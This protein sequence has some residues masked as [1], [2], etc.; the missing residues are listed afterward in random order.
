VDLNPDEVIRFFSFLNPSSSKMRLWL[1][2]LVVEMST[3]VKDDSHVC[4]QKLPDEK[5][6]VR[7]CVAVMQQQVLLSPNSGW[8]SYI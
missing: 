4:G 7:Q 2:Q 1:T 5:G 8:S 6:S 3:R